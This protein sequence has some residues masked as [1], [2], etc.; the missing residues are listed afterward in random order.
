MG[1]RAWSSPARPAARMAAARGPSVATT[2]ACL[3]PCGGRQPC[4]LEKGRAHLAPGATRAGAIAAGLPQHA[5]QSEHGFGPHFGGGHGRLANIERPFQRINRLIE[6]L[7][8]GQERQADPGQR[9][10]VVQVVGRQLPLPDREGL[11]RNRPA[12]A[13]FVPER[14]PDFTAVVDVQRQVGM[15]A[16]KRV[17]QNRDRLFVLLQRLRVAPQRMQTGSHAPQRQRHVP[18]FRRQHPPLGI[19]RPLVHDQRLGVLPV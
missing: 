10:A 4:R 14:Q 13:G 1:T 7:S 19:Q 2:P 3:G 11:V 15:L 8:L 5:R 18:V 6:R 17:F 12:P 16:T 9:V